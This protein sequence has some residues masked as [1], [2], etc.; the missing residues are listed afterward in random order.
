MQGNRER[1][2]GEWQKVEGSEETCKKGAG[3]MINMKEGTGGW[4]PPLGRLVS[5]LLFGK[6]TRSDR[7]FAN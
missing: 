2:A 3:R 1:G 4:E 7:Y 6:S 5:S